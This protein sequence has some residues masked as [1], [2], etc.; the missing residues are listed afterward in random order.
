MEKYVLYEGIEHLLR[1]NGGFLA[2]PGCGR[3]IRTAGVSSAEFSGLY[4]A[5]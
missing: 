4:C 5:N 3:V 2:L 1:E